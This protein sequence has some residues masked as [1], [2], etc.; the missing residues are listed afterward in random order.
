V[1]TRSDPVLINI[2]GII[3]GIYTFE[4]PKLKL[5]I[6]FHLYVELELG[7]QI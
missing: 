4:E 1:K 6:Q 7:Y 5:D 2:N 3:T